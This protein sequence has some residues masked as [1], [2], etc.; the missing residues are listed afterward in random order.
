[1]ALVAL[2]GPRGDG[3]AEVTADKR[4]ALWDASSGKLRQ[5]CQE[6]GH[7]TAQYTCLAVG[8][9]RSKSKSKSLVAVGE[10]RGRVVVWDL[11]KNAL[12]HAALTAPGAAAGAEAVA[13]VCFSVSCRTLF[14]CFEG[15]KYVF[16]FDL[17]DGSVVRK[18]KVG[19]HGAN[20]LC[21][22][23]DGSFLATAGSGIK[24]WSLTTG[25]KVKRFAGHSTPTRGLAFTPDCKHFVSCC[26]DRFVNLWSCALS[27]DTD[28]TPAK[29]KLRKSKDGD[30]EDDE[31]RLPLQRAPS[32]VFAARSPPLR[33][34][35]AARPGGS[36]VLSA[37]CEDDSATLWELDTREKAAADAATSVPASC[38]IYSKDAAAGGIV[39]LFLDAINKGEVLAVRHTPLRP[40]FQ[41]V[42]VLRS[43]GGEWISKVAL[44]GLSESSRL[45]AKG[46]AII[47]PE[48]EDLSD[49]ETTGDKVAKKEKMHVVKDTASAIPTSKPAAIAKEGDEEEELTMGERIK[50]LSNKLG[51][52]LDDSA[53]GLDESV[54]MGKKRPRELD[55]KSTA[56]SLGTVLEQALQSHDNK[57][58]EVVIRNTDKKVVNA[59]VGRL[60]STRV[61]DF[62]NVLVEKFESKPSRGF[63][64]LLWIKALLDQHAAYLVTVPNLAASL[65][66]LYQIVESRISVFSQFLRLQGRLEFVVS[67]AALRASQA[68]AEKVN[69]GPAVIYDEEA[70][71][72]E[73]DGSADEE[74]D[75]ADSDGSEQADVD[76]IANGEA[77]SESDDDNKDVDMADGDVPLADDDE[78]E[79][80]EEEQKAE[81]PKEATP[82]KSKGSKSK[83]PAKKSAA[84]TSTTAEEIKTPTP[85]KKTTPRPRRSTRHAKKAE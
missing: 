46:G 39:A 78:E 51:K 7:L 60:S 74:E 80:D 15:A 33:V 72:E 16:E 81:E 54:A 19:K 62:L 26:E 22:S 49:S 75:G 2:H 77:E 29:K 47:Q 79:D 71:A 68:Q 18:F 36:F 8:V 50:A 76:G 56:V 63:S 41:S 67:Q 35:V 21:V 5:A 59:T 73:V 84:K 4:V 58:I 32:K 34:A 45:V 20:R 57:L 25:A 64:L 61:L 52:H 30:A 66:G 44:D 28:A 38:V 82:R 69:K 6:Q 12:L 70:E 13:D 10:A 17:K 37:C 85:K 43:E 65:S 31:A 14:A 24:L 9:K 23:P 3:L 27:D 42:T 53:E 48:A 11:A 83:T 55:A 40:I 1:M